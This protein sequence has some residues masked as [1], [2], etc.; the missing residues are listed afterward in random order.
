MSIGLCVVWVVA[1]LVAA[2][3]GAEDDLRREWDKVV[4]QAKALRR[5]LPF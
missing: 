1:L 4:S 2:G 5:R 3:D